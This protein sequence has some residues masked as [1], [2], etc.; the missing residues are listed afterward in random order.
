M[1]TK[2]RVLLLGYNY[3]SVMNSLKTGFDAKGVK[4][5]AISFET[6]RR[7]INNFSEVDCIYPNQQII[8]WRFNLQRFK[9]ILKLIYSIWWCD[10]IHV[11]SDFRIFYRNEERRFEM[12]LLKL[13]NRK[14]FVNFLGSEIRDPEIEFQL[15]PFFKPAFEGGGYEYLEAESTAQSNHLQ[16][17]YSANGFGLIVWDTDLFIKEKHFKQYSIVPHASFNGNIIIASEKNK[18]V[19][20]VHAPSAPVAKGTKHVLAAIE[21]L[22]QKG[23]TGFDFELLTNIP[24]EEFRKKV[25]NCDIYIDQMVWG[26]Y[27]VATQQALEYGKVVV[28]YLLRQRIEKY[29]GAHCPIQNANPE[30]LAQVLEHLI[31]NEQLRKEIE[32]KSREYYLKMHQPSVVAEKM[33][34][35]YGY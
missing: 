8:P 32:V 21:T 18:T 2:P 24:N 11:F 19:K 15:N 23:I 9:G 22:H 1:K 3:A 25:I 33:L 31:A 26:A 35:A 13:F 14:R 20:I 12:F 28:C 16:Q 34:N 27:G 6:N 5:K 17:I 29:Y 4:V 7:I 30:T 10:V